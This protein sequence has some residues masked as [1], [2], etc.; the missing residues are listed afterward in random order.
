MVRKLASLLM[1]VAA[2]PLAASA[3]DDA[4]LVAGDALLTLSGDATYRWRFTARAGPAGV[5]GEL[6]LLA[7]QVEGPR[8]HGS[9]ACARADGATGTAR[10]AARVERSTT[11]LAP[12]GSFLVWT[13]VDNGED[14]RAA[15]DLA[16]E[17]VPIVDPAVA[18][19]HCSAGLLP[20]TAVEGGSI[21]VR[22]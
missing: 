13:V 17:L 20:L 6:E 10:L 21:Q 9:I 14:A 18:R 5:S 11:P 19:G 7:G 8:L 15:A 2:V 1:V 12:V 22:G 16:S 4:E 3:A